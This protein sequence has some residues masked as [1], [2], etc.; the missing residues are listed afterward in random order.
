VTQ[1]ELSKH[2]NIPPRTIS[3]YQ[4]LGCPKDLDGALAWVAD[5]KTNRYPG[6]EALKI[7]ST[8]AV[9]GSFEA[10]LERLRGEEMSLAGEIEA[11]RNEL[12][13]LTTQIGKSEVE[14]INKRQI[15]L[16]TRLAILRRQHL[17][18]SK[19]ASELE[20]KKTELS[21]DVISISALQDA[22]VRWGK[23][24]SAFLMHVSD[25]HKEHAEMANLIAAELERNLISIIE[26]LKKQNA[27]E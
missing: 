24:F 6:V 21:K 22:L 8:P 1:A 11:V 7:E 25:H 5:Y 9:D 18:I 4:S 12:L 16:N 10:R 14:A 3:Y 13:E 2:L 23:R 15:I 26:E 27:D 19:A 20:I 17:A